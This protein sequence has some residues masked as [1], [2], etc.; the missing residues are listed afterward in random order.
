MDFVTSL[1]ATRFVALT[2]FKRNGDAVATPMWIGGESRASSCGSLS[3][4]WLSQP[5]RRLASTPRM[6]STD[7][8]TGMVSSQSGER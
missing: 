8:G 4:R 1:A 5:P 6:A 2:T 7:G 3:T